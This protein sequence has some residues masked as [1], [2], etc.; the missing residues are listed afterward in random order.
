VVSREVFLESCR[1]GSSVSAATFYGD[2]DSLAKVAVMSTSSRSDT[3]DE[4][5]RCFSSDNGRS[6]SQWE[7]VAF[8]TRT[9][10]GVHRVSEC[11]GWVDPCEGPMLV[12]AIEGTLPTDS[13]LEGM[14]HWVLRYRVSLDA[15]R[16]F[17]VDEPVIQRGEYTPDHPLDGVWVG[18]N[19]FMIG[20]VSCRPIRTAAGHFLVP[21]QITPIGPDG[22]Y[23]N[24][25]GGYT[26]H[27]AAALIGTWT[28]DGRVEWDLSQRVAND[29]AKSTRGCV[30]PTLAE[31]PDGRV[32][33]VMRG[34][35]DAKPHLPARK[36][37]AVSED[38]GRT[39]TSPR[40]WTYS[41]G[42]E[43]FSPSSCSQLL[44]HSSGRYYWLGNICPGN[45]RGNRPRYP[46]VIGEVDPEGL[47]LV[48]DTVA[49][50]DTLQ[51]GEDEDLQLSNFF[52]YE[53][54]ES[55]EVLVHVTRLFHVNGW[56]GD[57][58]LYRLA[59]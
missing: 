48:E 40:P 23:Y 22:E 30:E 4:R 51:P 59:V 52:A 56:R 32:L 58:R 24:P 53:D 33:M 3:A 12:M 49:E 55:H 1:A 14:K 37:L 26:Y 38:A 6:W 11:P 34:S 27:E 45:A 29:P 57:A 7:P 21:V 31:M 28:D 42:G 17:A 47:G 9:D 35:N 13:P 19:C 46:L 44:H 20:A 5:A 2:L 50:I 16:S 54:R 36:W 10:A 8:I 15:G 41:G 43:F 39:W 25:G 18:K